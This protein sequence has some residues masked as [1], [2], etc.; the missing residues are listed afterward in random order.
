MC[1][2]STFR[3]KRYTLG[4]RMVLSA[5]GMVRNLTRAFRRWTRTIKIRSRKLP[6][7]SYC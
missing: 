5:R 2:A 1:A 4:M 7:E 3:A 6:R